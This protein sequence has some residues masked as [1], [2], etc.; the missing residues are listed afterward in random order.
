MEL[1]LRN[2]DNEELSIT[3]FN[4]NEYPSKKF[5]L[6][7]NLEEFQKKQIFKIFINIDEIMKELKTKI[8]K[9]IFIEETNSIIIDINMK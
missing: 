4:N 8:K 6:K 9:S 1:F 2:F 3:L 7:Y 5:E